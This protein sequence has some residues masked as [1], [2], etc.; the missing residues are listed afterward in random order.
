MAP[1]DDAVSRLKAGTADLHLTLDRQSR[2]SRLMA[3]GL[4]L[5]EYAGILGSLLACQAEIEP[6]LA[7]FRH[8]LAEPPQWLAPA[9]YRRSD[10]LRAD[11]QALGKAAVAHRP[12]PAGR[13]PQAGGVVIHG[14]AQAAGCMYVLAGSRLGGRL[15]EHRLREH[16]GDQ[17]A[18]ALRYFSPPSDTENW[19]WPSYRQS[20]NDMLRQPE[21]EREAL[22]A[23]RSVFGTFLRHMQMEAR[24]ASL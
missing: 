4:G 2:M 13:L 1:V 3:P 8:S 10:L 14:L 23:A 15:I 24:I 5:D 16:L 9:I 22:R 17:V 21:D 11:L 19:S 20:L 18:C 12:V 6:A 7:A